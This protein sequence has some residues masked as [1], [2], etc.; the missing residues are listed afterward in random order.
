MAKGREAITAYQTL[1]KFANHTLLEA[2]PVTGRTH[3]IRLHMAF[4]GCPV[5]GDTVY[6]RRKP[7]L[8]LDRHFLHAAHLTIQL[9]GERQPRNFTA[10]LP[11]ELENLLVYLRA[12]H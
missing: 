6:G 5:V 12:Q 2:H 4:L 11:A 10:P 8:P 1:E 9:P 3:Q 7:S